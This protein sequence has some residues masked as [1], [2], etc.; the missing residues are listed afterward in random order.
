MLVTEVYVPKK[1][2]LVE[3]LLFPTSG[4]HAEKGQHVLRF[5]SLSAL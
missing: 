2:N 3:N 5:L 4:M 1:F